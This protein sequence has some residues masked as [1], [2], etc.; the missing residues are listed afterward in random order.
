MSLTTALAP[1]QAR[2]TQLAARER[3]L[4]ALAA[5][6]VL[7]A[8]LWLLVLAPMVSTLRTADTRARALDAQLQQMLGLQAQVQN[9]QTQPPLRYDEA[10]K[11]L[12]LAT[13]QT[14]GKAAQVSVTGD[15]ASVTLQGAP[16]D[17]V[18]RWLAQARLN[19]RSVPV[20]ARLARVAATKDTPG[21]AWNGVLIM[22]L[23]AR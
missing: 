6:V 5:T 4:L 7:G 15:R 17:A 8:A 11:A 22:S 1:L 19:A 20:E 12:N 10:L 2:W 14:L 21:I 23:P 18:A 3:T 13:E 9:L 16:A